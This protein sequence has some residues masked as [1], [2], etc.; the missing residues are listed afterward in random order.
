MKIS[1]ANTTDI[2]PDQQL[3]SVRFRARYVCDLEG[4]VFDQRG[5]M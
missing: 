4:L 1:A 3:V 5:F 2:D